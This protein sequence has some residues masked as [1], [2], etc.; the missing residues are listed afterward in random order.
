M[1]RICVA[2]PLVRDLCVGWYFGG[3]PRGQDVPHTF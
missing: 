2:E 3:H 1:G